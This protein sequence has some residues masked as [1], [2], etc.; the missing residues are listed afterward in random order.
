MLLLAYIEG[1]GV[2]GVSGD[3]KG[4]GPEKLAGCVLFRVVCAPFGGQIQPVAASD[5]AIFYLHLTYTQVLC[6]IHAALRSG[7]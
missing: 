3:W 4:I 2:L 7:P 6:I 1:A 5:L